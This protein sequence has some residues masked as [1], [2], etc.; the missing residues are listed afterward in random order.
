MFSRRQSASHLNVNSNRTSI[1]NTRLHSAHH[2]IKNQDDKTLRPK[3]S[4]IR[5]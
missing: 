5:N 2:N 1:S 3:T 4:L